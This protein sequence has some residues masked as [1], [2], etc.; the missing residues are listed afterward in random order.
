MSRIFKENIQPLIET[1]ELKT[2]RTQNNTFLKQNDGK[3]YMLI[4]RKPTH[5][6]QYLNYSSHHKTSCKENVA[7]CLIKHIP[8]SPVKMT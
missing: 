1:T 5:A 3:I 2:S 8:L 6:D 7:P 4:Y